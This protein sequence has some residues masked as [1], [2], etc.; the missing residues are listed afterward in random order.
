MLF[1]GRAGESPTH[2]VLLLSCHVELDNAPRP[3]ETPR[4]RTPAGSLATGG[5]DE[6]GGPLSSAL[7]S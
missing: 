3:G 7:Q 5:A 4:T 2:C 1:R 6:A